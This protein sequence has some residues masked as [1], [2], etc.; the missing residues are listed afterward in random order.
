MAEKHDECYK[1]S[2]HFGRCLCLAWGHEL[3][4]ALAEQQGRI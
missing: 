4:L 1:K 2:E 3:A